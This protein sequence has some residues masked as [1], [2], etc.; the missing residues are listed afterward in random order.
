[1]LSIFSYAFM[2]YAGYS[3]H[4]FYAENYKEFTLYIMTY[5][6]YSSFAPISRQ[7]VKFGRQ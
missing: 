7:L 2:A 1:M 5:G 3:W 4:L 6:R